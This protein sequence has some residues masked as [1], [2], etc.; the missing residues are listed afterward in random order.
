MDKKQFYEEIDV[1]SMSK[2]E[3][4]R[5]AIMLELMKHL[6]IKKLLD[7]GCVPEMTEYFTSVLNCNGVG[8]NIS[9][10]VIKSYKGRNKNLKFICG[11]AET[12]LPDGKFDLVICGELIEHIQYP[13]SFIEN[14][15][16]HIND[17]GYL[18][19]TMPNLASIF[20]RISLLL[21]WQPR[22]INPSRKLLF[23][24]FTKYDYNWGHVSMF[25][26]HSIR[27]F[28]E[29]NGFKILTI[30]GVHGGNANESNVHNFLRAAMSAKASFA[31]QLIILARKA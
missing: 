20:N 7:I 26:H 16:T 19:L 18:L 25:T 30:K 6:G 21:G 1:I 24:P 12:T 17:D 10:R 14:V 22:G 13:D 3:K 5:A 28:L 31:E 27:K 2:Y 8:L 11:D 29:S 23:N 9:E 15:K 4:R